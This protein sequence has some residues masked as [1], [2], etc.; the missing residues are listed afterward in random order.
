M[1]L[2]S[3]AATTVALVQQGIGKVVEGPPTAFTP[4]AF[5]SWPV[6]IAPPGPD[7]VA[8]TPG[9]LEWAIFPPERVEIS[10][11]GIGIEELMEIGEHGHR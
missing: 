5:D 2:E 9:A 6:M 10:M 7:V 8:V 11:A 1:S 3:S 4:V